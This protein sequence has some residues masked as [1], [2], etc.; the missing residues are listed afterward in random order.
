MPVAV[1]TH[2][3]W[4]TVRAAPAAR[5]HERLDAPDTPLAA[6]ARVFDRPSVERL[7]ALRHG[8]TPHAALRRA[9]LEPAQDMLRRPGKRFR[10][11]LA[12]IGWALAG[13]PPP[14]PPWLAQAIEV[15]HAGSMI[16]DDVEDG[17]T[18]RRG[19][20]AL[21]VHWGVPQAINTGNLLYF[22]PLAMLDALELPAATALAVHRR[23]GQTM[24]RA[25][26]G[27]GLD[28]TIN[29]ARHPQQEV[30][31]V[32]GAIS[33]LK[34]GSLMA[35]AATLGGVIRGAAA[36][37]LDALERF[38]AGLGIALQMLDDH[39]NLGAR[40]PH[41]AHEDLRLGRAT[42]V[43]A[44]LAARAAPA[45][46]RRLQRLSL[47]VQRGGVPPAVLA[48]ELRAA[49][50]ETGRAAARAAAA[51]AVAALRL[52][53]GAHPALAVIERECARLEA[54]YG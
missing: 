33:E 19:E 5:T 54:S 35:L 24:L 49:L 8:T 34:T 10:A 25:H 16:I 43:W 9:V 27:Q 13:G 31:Q 6:V 28:V 2:P 26:C 21:H 23:I 47:R 51:A 20:A 3:P 18:H 22:L 42:W 11:Q 53:V 48:D 50:G 45:G 32:V 7:L 15:L 44:W 14:P 29:V 37:R 39:G 17:S 12:E 1:V 46:Y 4:T 36:P 30:G 40:D 41:K 52:E 38:G